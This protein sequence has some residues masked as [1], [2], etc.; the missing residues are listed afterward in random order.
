MDN[1]ISASILT[2]LIILV[3]FTTISIAQEA[4][5]FIAKVEGLKESYLAGNIE[6]CLSILNEL[7]K[8]LKEKKSSQIGEYPD[9][10]TLK[11]VLD[12]PLDVCSI[13]SLSVDYQDPEYKLRT[14]N[15]VLSKIH[16][17]RNTKNL[18]QVY[19]KY[20]E[21][22]DKLSSMK[23]TFEYL[24]ELEKV[25]DRF[26][27]IGNNFAYFLPNDLSRWGVD[28]IPT[29]F[30]NVNGRTGLIITNVT[31]DTQDKD[32]ILR[33]IQK[34]KLWDEKWKR[35]NYQDGIINKVLKNLKDKYDWSKEKTTTEPRSEEKSGLLTAGELLKRDRPRPDMII[36]HGL[37]PYR[38]YTVLVSSLK[39][40]KTALAMQMCLSIISGKEFLGFPIEQETPILFFHLADTDQDIKELLKRQTQGMKLPAGTLD[41]LY[42]LAPLEG[43]HLQGFSSISYIRE[44]IEETKAGLIVIDPVSLTIDYDIKK[45]KTKKSLV[46]Y[47]KDI[48]ASW[49][50]IK[51]YEKSTRSKSIKERALDNS[52]WGHQ[53]S[54]FIG[55]EQYNS[56]C[57]S[58]YKR[59]IL[60]PSYTKQ[61]RDLC[62]YL[63]PETGLFKVVDPNSISKISTDTVAKI[64]EEQDSPIQHKDLLILVQKKTGRSE[65]A[66]RSLIAKAKTEGKVKKGGGKFGLY[67]I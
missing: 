12:S 42:P 19:D 25:F 22:K 41:S 29:I 7:E 46:E 23:L 32:Q 39:E 58:E 55:I 57:P 62:I 10:V 64:L 59:L 13:W 54:S 24:D 4:D 49:L 66:A 47:T 44:K 28:G 61:S 51:P 1:R 11:E 9:L 35:K 53:Y 43:L 8:L 38:G 40:G 2:V 65:R 18:N 34:S 26:D 3:C 56:K 16:S 20:K 15:D 31:T 50:F 60:K 52:G 63:N 27:L 21:I 5:S 6:K 36:G 17:W 14:S 48:E 45:A 67:S 37:L 33:I 30:V